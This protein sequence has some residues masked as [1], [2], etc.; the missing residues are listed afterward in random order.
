MNMMTFLLFGKECFGPKFSNKKN[1][2]FWD[3][4]LKENAIT[5]IFNIG[6]FVPLL[7]PFDL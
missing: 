6:D 7:E 3:I 1:E 5:S 2:E 4:I